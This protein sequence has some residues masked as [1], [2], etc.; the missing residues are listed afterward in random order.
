MPTQSLNSFIGQWLPRLEAEMQELLH[1]PVA[2]NTDA[3]FANFYGMMQYHMGWTDAQFQPQQMPTGKRLRP[4]MCLMACEEVG[5]D[6]VQAL[7]AAGAIE[8]LHNFSLVHD[9]I[10]DGDETRRHRPTVWKLTGV[11]L[12]INIGD[13][14]FALAYQAIQNLG[15][16]G[17]D[18]KV[19]LEALNRFTQTCIELT[20][21]QH[22][23]MSFEQ[24]AQVKVGEYIR[25]IEGKT[26][27]LVGATVSIGA[28]IG[29]ATDEQI[30][31]LARFGQSVGLAFQVQDDIL[32]IWGDPEV[33]GK[34]AGNDILR[35]K[36]S[37]PLLYALNHEKI[38]PKLLTIWQGGFGDNQLPR[39]LE[40]LEESQA[41]QFAEEQVQFHHENAMT[42]LTDAL[43]DRAEES[44]LRELAMSLVNRSS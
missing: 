27:S 33:T 18:P 12:A 4:M 1:Y 41:R 35:Q 23:D 28:L 34:A 13:G 38:G 8:I 29:N 32:G 36:K 7:P 25:M 10:E 16:R 2:D 43:G 42:A 20:Q 9:D 30:K 22:M 24:R 5:G 44:M 31:S 14:M 11:P 26:A 21:G 39:V 40:L 19:V 37:L 3:E 15:R 6:P 17:V